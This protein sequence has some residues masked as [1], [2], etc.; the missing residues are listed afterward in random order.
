MDAPALLKREGLV[1]VRLGAE[2]A[3]DLI[4]DATETCGGGEG[5]EPAHGPVA[6]F[7]AL[8]NYGSLL[9]SSHL[10]W[11]TRRMNPSP[12]P[13]AYQRHRFPAEII[14]HCVWLYFRF[15]LSYRDVEELMAERGVILTYEAVR[16][17]CRKFAHSTGFSGSVCHRSAKASRRED[18]QI[19]E[20]IMCRYSSAFDFHATLPGMLGATLVGHQV[21]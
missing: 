12:A 1:A 14:S 15:C 6:L 17:W 20:P 3:S 2:K 21:V 4:K 5:F 9:S 11:H 13:N 19:K 8:S 16:Y 10:A 7:K 18:L